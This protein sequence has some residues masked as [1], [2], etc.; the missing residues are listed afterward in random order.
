M[1]GGA[2]ILTRALV[3][4]IVLQSPGI[5][6][7]N[8]L[9]RTIVEA[10]G[11][12]AQPGFLGVGGAV[13]VPG[14]GAGGAL[15]GANPTGTS[16]GSML[17][18][19]GVP[20]G[21]D[22][23]MGSGDTLPVDS[24]GENSGGIGVGGSVSAVRSESD[25][26]QE[27]AVEALPETAGGLLVR[28]AVE[29]KARPSSSS[30]VLGRLFDRIRLRDGPAPGRETTSDP[31]LAVGMEAVAPPGITHHTGQAPETSPEVPAPG[32][33]T[34]P[35]K[36]SR[37]WV[38]KAA[39]LAAGFLALDWGTKLLFA[40][41]GLPFVYHELGPVRLLVMKFAV[42]INLLA[43]GYYLSLAHAKGPPLE[44]LK[45]FREKH[46]FMGGILYGLLQVL[47]FP[48]GLGEKRYAG[49]LPRKYPPVKTMQKILLWSAAALAA[50][51]LGNGLEAIFNGKVVDFIPFGHGRMNLAD[52]YIF[53]GLPLLWMGLDFFKEA[54]KS[55]ETDKPITFKT[56]RYNILPMA[57]LL[58]FAYST[59]WGYDKI[60]LPAWYLE[61]FSVL[62]SAG[63]F[64][65]SIVV[66]KLVEAYNRRF[67][68]GP[69][70]T[71]TWTEWAKEKGHSAG[72]RLYKFLSWD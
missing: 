29:I 43:A 48:V 66:S 11:L 61:I 27:T 55:E 60:P 59:W 7:Y 4:A 46:P 38:W 54:R 32:R 16:L 17:E 5:L 18:L 51:G 56:W 26:V 15:G 71:Q 42:P 24:G 33:P 45:R 8:I 31:T 23:Q 40:A 47:T 41:T 53:F 36:S 57:G 1:A 9:A 63:I 28:G 30:G 67:T 10:P 39:G 72:Q 14:A 64:A 25:L 35:G 34:T 44:S 68:P 12:A 22:F 21:T 62:F 37:A 2:R 3:A 52:V 13:L 58:V 6:S 20:V 49:D 50:A 65:A 69:P 19:P 70:G